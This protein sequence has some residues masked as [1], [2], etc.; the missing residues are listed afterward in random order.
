MTRLRKW[1]YAFGNVGPALTGNVVSTYIQFFYVDVLGLATALM[2]PAML[3]YALWNAINDPIAGY[4]SDRTHT[5]WGRRIPY[6]ALLSAPMCLFF[7]LIWVVPPAIV[8]QQGALVAWL[9]VMLFVYDVLGTFVGLNLVAL[10]PEMYGDLADR[11]EVSSYRQI[12]A[13]LF[14]VGVGI[15]LPSWLYT[16][17]GWGAMGVLF[18][19]M[20]ALALY[21]SLRGSHER[22]LTPESMNLRDALR[23]TFRNR[24]F[25][26]YLTAQIAKEFGTLLLVAALPF[27]AKYVLQLTEGMTATL[28][29][30]V[31]LVALP[32]S[33]VWS[34][35]AVKIG[36][37]GAMMAAM[38]CFAVALFPF[39]FLSD[40][41]Q[42]VVT[43]ALA[44]I[45]LGGMFVLPDI[46]LSDVIDE[47]AVNTGMRREGMYFGMQG[48][49]LRLAIALQ[50]LALNYILTITGYVSGVGA[51]AQSPAVAVGLRWALAVLP[52]AGLALAILSLVLYPLHG[53]RLEALHASMQPMS[54][55]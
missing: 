36:T 23:T 10:L 48:L 20:A 8:S 3:I 52:A 49:L 42:A 31:F 25:L 17:I 27:Y 32:L 13:L 5:R 41:T 4:L 21:V 54:N 50:A 7:A 2:G 55:A 19:L 46:L 28:L 33:L 29:A 24:S 40:F 9:L 14:G 22:N 45:G 18:G 26:T 44:G 43:C 12:F 37:R 51:A 15:V 38:A 47:D 34:R 6:I 1:L 53:K 11:A 39:A 30:P 16:T 35:I